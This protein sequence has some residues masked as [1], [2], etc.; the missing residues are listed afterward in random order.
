MPLAVA[1]VAAGG[2]PVW[3]GVDVS[4]VGVGIGG[5]PEALGGRWLAMEWPDR[6][7][8][9]CGWLAVVVGA[10]WLATLNGARCDGL[11]AYTD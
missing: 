9:A 11:F 8:G 2:G 5:A 7:W 10:R 3:L 4:A 1:V 6:G